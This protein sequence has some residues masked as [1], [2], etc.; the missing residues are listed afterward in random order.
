LEVVTQRSEP[1][2]EPVALDPVAALVFSALEGGPP[3]DERPFPFGYRG[4]PQGGA[5]VLHG[6]RSAQ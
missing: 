4:D 3:L 6:E 1:D 5:V 2:G